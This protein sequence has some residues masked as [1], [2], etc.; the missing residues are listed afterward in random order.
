MNIPA[1]SQS[2]LC[3]SVDVGSKLTHISAGLCRYVD[4]GF[5]DKHGDGM[6]VKNLNSSWFYKFAHVKQWN[7]SRLIV[8]EEA[9]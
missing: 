2:V 4:V 6:F 5:V 1:L 7:N 9:R 3:N 8:C